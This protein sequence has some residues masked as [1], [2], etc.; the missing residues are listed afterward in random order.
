MPMEKLLYVT[1]HLSTGGLPQYLLKQI[2]FF[3]DSFEIYC[4]EWDDITG[5]VFVVQRNKIQEILGDRLVTIGDDKSNFLDL[6]RTIQ[7][8]IIHFQEIPETFI[9]DGIL[10]ELYLNQ[11]TY[12]D[13]KILVT[14]HSSFTNPATIRYTA[15]KFVLVSDWSKSKFEQFYNSEIPCDVWEYP[16]EPVE[17]SKNDANDLLNFDKNFKHV[18]HVGLFTPGKNQKHI[19]EVAKKCLNHNIQF[20][21]VGN[22]A[23]NFQEY[24]K[25]LMEDF[26]KNCIWHG[27][28]NDVDSFYK[29]SDLFYFPSKFELAPISLKDARSFGLPMFLTKL[30]TYGTTYDDTAT[31]I[32]D[33]IDDA[34]DKLLN[35]FELKNNKK[36]EINLNIP[37]L[38]I[39]TDIDSPREIKS[40][41]SL[42]KLEDY[43]ITYVPII[44]KRYM[45]LPPAETCKNPHL[46]DANPGGKLTPAHY[47][48]YLG[49]R[50]AFESGI[51][52]GTDFIM[53]FECDAVIAVSNDEF[54]DRLQFAMSK[55]KE[56]N[57]L[58]FSFGYH[59]NSHI[60]EKKSDY[61]IV[62]SF[63]GAQSYLIPR[64]SYDIIDAVY[65]NSKW[66]V[67]DL[68]FNDNFSQFKI[69]IFENPVVKQTT[70]YSIL[71]KIHNDDRY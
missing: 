52:M 58:M 62:N 41:Q 61:W 28:R 40:M 38:H 65:K 71:D 69:G 36:P 66:N 47:G 42:T 6:V 12:F 23:M 1:P 17:Y 39:L 70:G 55:T 16:I 33:D 10:D 45:D 57:L 22:Q 49:H 25:P 31:Y 26:P 5:G 19:I 29:A 59:N 32:S 43:G 53:I 8:N 51:K 56:D 34:V 20:H 11:R 64:Q 30:E 21:F 2:E 67:T 68:F 48:C 14:T 37:F 3:N 13:F 27:E 7:P 63:Y 9:S 46:I 18:L 24:W 60:T 50:K 15:D 54:C 4:A 35:H 44:S